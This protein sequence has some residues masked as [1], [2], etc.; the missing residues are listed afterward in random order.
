M[1][2]D[3]KGGAGGGSGF[4]TFAPHRRRLHGVYILGREISEGWRRLTVLDQMHS[5]RRRVRS[6]ARGS[7]DV[8]EVVR[9]V[10]R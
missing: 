3:G 2:E 8:E 5:K 7:G 10:W 1:A 6:T 9:N 4:K